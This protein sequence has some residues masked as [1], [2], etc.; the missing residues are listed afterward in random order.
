MPA[1]LNIPIRKT[2][3]NDNTF[4]LGNQPKLYNA[5]LLFKPI[6]LRGHALC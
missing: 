5:Y 2:Y 3:R 6:L 4:H 1:E